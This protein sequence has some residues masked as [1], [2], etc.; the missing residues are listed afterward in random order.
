MAICPQCLGLGVLDG[1]FPPCP[2]CNGRGDNG[3]RRDVSCQSC[4]GSGKASVRRKNTCWNCAGTG[5]VADPPK[6]VP[7]TGGGKRAGSRGSGGK[8]AAKSKSGLDTLGKLIAFG[9]AVAAGVWSQATTPDAPIVWLIAAF[10]AG[11]IT[12]AL[13]KLMI[14]G[15]AAFLALWILND[16]DDG[17]LPVEAASTPVPAPQTNITPIPE[18]A[19]AGFC[20]TNAT[21]RDIDFHYILNRRTLSDSFALQSGEKRKFWSASE[22]M[23]GISSDFELVIETIGLTYDLNIG[24]VTTSSFAD[25]ASADWPDC[26]GNGGLPDYRLVLDNGEYLINW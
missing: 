19:G 9:A 17:K 14:I 12:Y 6:T 5:R 26:G 10:L 20:V 13:R 8:G 22:S 3:L 25:A 23:N 11:V 1:D 4:G 2:Q 21:K 15:G 24:R 18:V 16:A 7:P